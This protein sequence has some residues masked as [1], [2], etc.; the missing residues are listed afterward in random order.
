M[1]IRRK[2]L[3][4]R[5][6][7]SNGIIFLFRKNIRARIRGTDFYNVIPQYRYCWL[8]PVTM[9]SLYVSVNMLGQY[10]YRVYKLARIISVKIPSATC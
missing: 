6:Y 5:N 8:T 7:F 9:L 4:I 2:V 3:E 1:S 10:L